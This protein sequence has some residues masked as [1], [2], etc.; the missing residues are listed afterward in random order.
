MSK[1]RYTIKDIAIKLDISVSTVSRVLRG[2]P[3]VNENTRRRVLSMVEALNYKRNPLAMS[4]ASKKSYTIGVIV[5]ELSVPFFGEAIT[6]MQD[7]LQNNGYKVI[8]CPTGESYENEVNQVEMLRENRVDG[9]IISVSKETENYEHL[10]LAKEDLPVVMFDRVIPSLKKD[11]SKVIVNDREGA[12]NA[13]AHLI[14]HGYKRIAHISGPKNLFICQERLMGYKEALEV[15]G[16][17]FDESLLIHCNMRINASKATLQLLH[18]ENRPDAIFAIN[19]PVA[20][21]IM[22]K[23]TRLGIKIPNEMGVIGYTGSKMAKLFNPSLSTIRQPAQR[24]GEEA[25]RLILDEI[26]QRSRNE[27]NIEPKQIEL[28]T[29]LISGESSIK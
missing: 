24:M 13:T 20:F 16:L 5:P 15:Y 29:E 22:S 12:F 17:E 6:G 9:I 18:L 2:A 8:V 23:L 21:E 14:E 28:P 1:K 19:D 11:F 7:Y 3:D 26:T 25:A 4:L 27:K 10:Y